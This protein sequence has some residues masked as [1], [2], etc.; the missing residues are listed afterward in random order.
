MVARR[1]PAPTDPVFFFE[2]PCLLITA[3][4]QGVTFRARALVIRVK[5]HDSKSQIYEAYIS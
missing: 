5:I 1:G 4:N 3:E 2:N